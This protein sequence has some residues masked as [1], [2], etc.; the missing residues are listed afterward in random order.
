MR[1]ACGGSCC[2]PLRKRFQSCALC[3]T[4]LFI[5]VHSWPP[6]RVIFDV[7][8]TV[9]VVY[10]KQEQA[11]IGYNPT[12]RGRPSYHPLLCFEGQSRDFWH[13]ELRPGDVLPPAASSTF[14]KPA[15]PRFL[16]A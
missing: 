1:Q 14:S 8:S 5:T 13:G 9:L 3:T 12:K 7:D 15:S 4:A 2:A 16:R 11:R 10:G 6:T